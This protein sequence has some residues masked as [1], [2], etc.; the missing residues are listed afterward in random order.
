MLYTDINYYKPKSLSEASEILMNNDNTALIAGGTDLL[1]EIKK[2]MRTVNNFVSLSNIIELKKIE[3]VADNFYIGAGL[4]HSEIISSP[5]IKS[6][7]P[8]LSYAASK[9]GSHQIRNVGTIGGNLCTAAS[10][11]DTAPILLAYD[12]LIELAMDNSVRTLPLKEFLIFHHKT[13]IKTN[14]IMTRI[15]IPKKKNVNSAYFEK[16][17][18]REASSISVASSAVYMEFES[19]ICNNIKIVIGACSPTPIISDNANQILFDKNID[20]LKNNKEII[21]TAGIAASKDSVPIDDIRGSADYR[22]HLVKV[23]TCKALFN[24]IKQIN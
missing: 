19:G 9:I 11:A 18:I 1:V 12:S 14:E 7:I 24:A 13:A 17:G 23:L 20:D 10:C 4:T 21:E 22:R 3:E 16:F 5:L 2:G 6:K 15:I 8:A